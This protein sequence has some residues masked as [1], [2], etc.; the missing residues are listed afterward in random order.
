M[1]ADPKQTATLTL[2][3][4]EVSLPGAVLVYAISIEFF[5][6]TIAL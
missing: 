2:E 1:G 4:G 6:L 3:F 5:I